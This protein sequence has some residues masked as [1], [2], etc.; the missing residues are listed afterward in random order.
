VMI[1]G[2]AVGGGEVAE[3]AMLKCRCEKVPETLVSAISYM[4]SIWKE[5]W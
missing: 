4:L 5:N 3:G 2:S 1:V